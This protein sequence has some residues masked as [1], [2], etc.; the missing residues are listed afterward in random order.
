[1]AAWSG[2]MSEIQNHSASLGEASRSA[3]FSNPVQS[4]KDGPRS[5][6]TADASPR[7]GCYLPLSHRGGGELP[8]RSH[9]DA[10][11]EAG[12]NP[13]ESLG[14]GSPLAPHGLRSPGRGFSPL[15]SE[16]RPLIRFV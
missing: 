3:T 14:Q 2:V 7:R 16:P 8:V 6:I 5:S 13:M 1:M 12:G 9:A 4:I 10:I 15:L 11:W